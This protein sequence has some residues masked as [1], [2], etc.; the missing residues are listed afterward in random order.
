[1]PKLFLLLLILFS[2]QSFSQEARIVISAN[3]AYLFAGNFPL[4]IEPVINA[5][6][7][8]IGGAGLTFK[9]PLEEIRQDADF[10]NHDLFLNR[11]S[12]PGFSLHA[13]VKY[14][15]SAITEAPKAFYL[16]PEY[17]FKNYS[18]NEEECD[19]SGNKN[20][21]FF[22]E[23]RVYHDGKVL[24]GYQFLSGN[25]AIDVFAGLGVRYSTGT[26]GRCQEDAFGSFT[27]SY[28]IYSLQRATPIIAFGI[29]VGGVF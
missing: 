15:L 1:M 6:L 19:N 25:L 2:Q 29:K 5:H 14:Y 20:G 28:H 8:L 18:V 21:K 12:L 17:Q 16:E 13:G 23:S 11:K 24:C 26:Y 4:Y 3:P 27:Y 10:D 9:E 7:S 22:T